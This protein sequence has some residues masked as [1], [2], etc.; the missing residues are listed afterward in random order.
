M[1]QPKATATDRETTEFLQT[2]GALR[3]LSDNLDSRAMTADVDLATYLLAQAARESVQRLA[4][5]VSMEHPA[6]A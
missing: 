5:Y 1:S 4:R 2:V 6:N 3:A